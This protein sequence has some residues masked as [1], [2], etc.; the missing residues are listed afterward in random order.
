M[1]AA[2][3]DWNFMTV[4]IVVALFVLWKMEFA[5]TLLNLKAF[6]MS[7]PNELGDVMDTPKL[8]QARAYLTANSRFDV[9]QS[10]TSLGVLLVFWFAGGFGW[11]DGWARS[12]AP[13]AVTA[14]LVFLSALALGQSLISLPFSIHE[15]F[16]I[17]KKFGFNQTT[18]ATFIIDRLKAILLAAVIGL[19]LAAAVLWIFGN[20]GH[21]WL[22]AWAVV[23]TFQLLLTWLAPSLIMPLF[24]KFTPMPEGQL[25]QQIEAL[26]ARCAFPLA[27]VFVMDGSKRSTKANAFFSGF[28]KQKKIAL[29]DTL[30]EKSTTPELL[31]VLAH[32]IGHFRRGHIKQRLAAGILQT[33]VIFFLLGL[34]TDPHGRFARLLFDA[35]G[36]PQISPHVGLVLFSILLEP[37]SKLLGVGLNAWSRHH[38]FE[39]DAYAAAATGDGAPLAAA[40]KKM[41]SDHLS[42]PTPAALRVW[43]DYSH[44]PLLQRLRA[45][46]NP[47][48][49]ETDR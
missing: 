49:T 22:W 34:A 16:V 28:G 35:F 32:E 27:G 48:R 6:P 7:V 15:T 30:L 44:P 37:V 29:F 10:C 18:P 46:E 13:S 25:K 1:M 20:V 47:D 5:A 36:V 41:T 9:V 24:N 38:E 39:A 19:P 17:E 40:L 26:G 4:I 21:A 14:G 23:T 43:L 31:G 42:H 8:E 11:L 45:L 3:S 2:M 33:A 12:L